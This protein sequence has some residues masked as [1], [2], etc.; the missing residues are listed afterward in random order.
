[1]PIQD[2]SS[3]DKYSTDSMNANCSKNLIQNLDM[4]EFRALDLKIKNGSANKQEN[5]RFNQLVPLI[6]L[7]Q[8]HK[9]DNMGQ[10]ERQRLFKKHINAYKSTEQGDDDGGNQFPLGI[11]T[12]ADF[13]IATS[14]NLDLV[15]YVWVA[16]DP[17][18]KLSAF[19][20][21]FCE[22]KS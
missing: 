9:Y 16:Q 15:E 21:K 3:E 4:E 13:F 5:A 14:K 20:C 12:A 1:M 10:Q 2:G 7:K 8:T 22:L 18:S 19:V 6:A 11:V 17:M